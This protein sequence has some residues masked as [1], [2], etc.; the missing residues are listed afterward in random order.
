MAELCKR[1]G[2]PDS[3]LP[4]PR[5][6]PVWAAQLTFDGPQLRYQVSRDGYV[7]AE[8]ALSEPGRW[9]GKTIAEVFRRLGRPD[10]ITSWREFQTVFQEGSP[11]FSVVLIYQRFANRRWYITTDGTVF[12]IVGGKSQFSATWFRKV[13]TDRESVAD[14]VNRLGQPD[15]HPDRQRVLG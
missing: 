8:I 7:L 5:G 12:A 10:M 1:L 14:L 4:A 13:E 9:E 2:Q 15:R 6:S 3:V 11:E